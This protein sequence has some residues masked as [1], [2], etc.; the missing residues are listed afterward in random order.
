MIPALKYES[1]KEFEHTFDEIDILYIQPQSKS[2]TK[3]ADLLQ[4]QNI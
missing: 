2:I 1:I 4:S 3:A